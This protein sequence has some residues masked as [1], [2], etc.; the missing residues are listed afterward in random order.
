MRKKKSI[1]LLYIESIDETIAEINNDINQGNYQGLSERFINMHPSDLASILDQS[2]PKIQQSIINAIKKVFNPEILAMA[3]NTSRLTVLQALGT[4]KTAMLI[5]ELDLEDS[6]D[7]LDSYDDE[8]K[9]QLIKHLSNQKQTDVKEGLNYPEDCVGRIMETNFLIF[10]DQWSIDQAINSI[11]RYNLDENLHAAVIVDKDYRPTGTVHLS[12][13]FQHSG[14]VTLK[15]IANTEIKIADINDKINDLVYFFK[16]YALAII[17]VVNK[18]GKL[19]GS[20][21]IENMIYIIEESTESDILNLTGVREPDTFSTVIETAKHRFLWLFMNLLIAF[22][23]AMIINRFSHTISRI[24]ALAS[25][26][27]IV[28]SMGGNAGAQAMTV[29]VRAISKKDINRSNIFRIILK[30]VTVCTLNSLFLSFMGGILIMLI[31][32]DIKL[33][34]IFA[35]SVILNFIV[36]GLFGSLIP[37]TLDN[38]ELDPATASSVFLTALTDCFGFFTFLGLSFLIL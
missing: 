38:F 8:I 21:S 16:Q 36:A 34:L 2:S 25:I 9:E 14:N 10:A 20:V 13:L 35:A 11:R 12:K 31:Y 29:T 28:A 27:P 24:I 7:V 6:I 4:Q 1:K 22:V 3:G 33:S 23:T 32:S 15:K 30:E 19:V 37:I 18:S 17:P 5:E 26:M